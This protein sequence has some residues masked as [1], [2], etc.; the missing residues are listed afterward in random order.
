M[1]PAIDPKLLERER[2]RGEAYFRREYLAEF[3]DASNPLLPPEAIDAAIMRGVAQHEPTESGPVFAGIDLADKR[4]DCALAISAVREVDGKRKV[5]LLFAKDWKPTARGHNVVAILEE[6]GELCRRYHV[7]LARG[8]QKSM[9]TA[10]HILGRFGVYFERVITDGQGSERMYRTFLA[11]LNNGDVALL[12][13]AELLT[14]LRRLEERTGDGGRFRVS[15]RRGK[16]DLA[17]ASVLAVSMGADALV[18]PE[19]HVHVLTF[20]QNGRSSEPGFVRED[21][22]VTGD[23]P[24]RWWNPI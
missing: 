24:E 15:G 18:M 11:V 6:M 14:Q 22:T 16:D 20:D 2:R 12:D 9:S 4:D 13:D 1:N 3:T 19:P 21:G 23:G 17:V 10:E 5:T 8:D 7:S